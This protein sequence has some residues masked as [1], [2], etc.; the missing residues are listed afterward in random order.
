[1][2]FF[3]LFHSND[4]QWSNICFFKKTLN[5]IL[6]K[7]KGEIS[8]RKIY[9]WRLWSGNILL[10]NQISKR[11]SQATT[12]KIE[13]INFRYIISSTIYYLGSP[14]FFVFLCLHLRRTFFSFNQY[15]FI[16][17]ITC[18]RDV[19]YPFVLDKGKSNTCIIH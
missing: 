18:I 3:C 9:Q 2:F 15:I 1:M 14:N 7:F 8:T 12:K 10:N 19:W 5:L 6:E 4:F 13:R 17:L 11:S 16:G